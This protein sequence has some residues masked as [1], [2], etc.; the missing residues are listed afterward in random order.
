ELGEEVIAEL[1]V[2]RYA[3]VL[4]AGREAQCFDRLEGE[5]AVQAERAF[6]GY[7]PVAEGGVGEDLGLGCFLEIEEGAANALDVLGGEFAV[8][9]A[10]VL[11][12][13]LEPL[14]RVDELHLAL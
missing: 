12:Q 11:A 10:E 4:I 8:F 9:L 5:L 7:L 13:R 2:K 1:V 3:Q 6:N 14:T